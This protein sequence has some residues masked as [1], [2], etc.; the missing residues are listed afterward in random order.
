MAKILTNKEYKRLTDEYDKVKYVCRCGHR[1]IIP[2]WADKT[3]CDWCN[4]FV[5]KNKEEEDKYRIREE[6]S[7][8]KRDL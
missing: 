3:L 4:H 8:M 6:I 7:K 2:N 1:V 5:F